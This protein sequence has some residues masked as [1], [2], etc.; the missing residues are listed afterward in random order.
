M[1][2]NGPSPLVISSSHPSEPIP[3]FG[4]PDLG[5]GVGC[6][7]RPPVRWCPPVSCLAGPRVV[8]SHLAS[9]SCRSSRAH[10]SAACRRRRRRRGGQKDRDPGATSTDLAAASA[11]PAVGSADPVGA[12]GR[13]PFLDPIGGT[14]VSVWKERSWAWICL[15]GCCLATGRSCKLALGAETGES[16]RREGMR[17]ARGG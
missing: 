1:P 4:G 11:D 15:S 8:T 3:G 13:R 5:A 6:Q 12:V 2:I 10:L 17:G 16:N 14:Q 7:S 9:S